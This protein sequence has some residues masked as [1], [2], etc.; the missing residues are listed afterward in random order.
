MSNSHLTEKGIIAITLVV[1]IGSGFTVGT[2]YWVNRYDFVARVNGE[3]ISHTTFTRHLEQASLL[4]T[5]QLGLDLNTEK[6][7]ALLPML[8]QTTL[9]QLIEQTLMLQEAKRQGIQ[10]SEAEIQSEYDKYLQN[11]YQGDK[12]RMERE[13]AHNHYS[14]ADFREELRKRLL[15]QKLK[16]QLTRTVKLS[17]SQIESYYNQNKTRFISPEK[18]E[19]RHILIK[20]QTPAQEEKARSILAQV[21]QE[22]KA[23][24]DFA[25]LAKKYSQDTSTKDQGGSL[26]AFAK[27]EMVK[28]FEQAAWALQ[29]GEYTQKPVKTEYGLH[30]ILRGKTIPA[31]TLSL[32]EA[33]KEF[34]GQLHESQKEQFFQNWLKQA[35]AHAEIE[36]VESLNFPS[37]TPSSTTSPASSTTGQ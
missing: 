1:F 21:L 3:R 22:L 31:R 37:P 20:S 26:G 8:K 30:L 7:K 14:P 24:G 5:R 10:V 11:T 16:K 27:G 19:A 4:Y 33:R 6:G 29:P 17:E 36:I 2:W 13:L 25:A 12:A 34:E 23:G 28:A 18:I 35:R 32:Q 9:N 15:I